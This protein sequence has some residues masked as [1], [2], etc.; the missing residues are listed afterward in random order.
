MMVKVV[1][2]AWAFGP[3]L[4]EAE[5][6]HRRCSIRV[7]MTMEEYRFD[8]RRGDIGAAVRREVVANE[9]TI[10]AMT[11]VDDVRARYMIVFFLVLC[12]C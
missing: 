3:P 7:S 2:A 10:I 1:R 8:R 6:R 11:M 5:G 4:V 9:V 12:F